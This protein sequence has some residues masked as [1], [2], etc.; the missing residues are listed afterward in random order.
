MSTAK[1]LSLQKCEAVDM[2]L[3]SAIPLRPRASGVHGGIIAIDASDTTLEFGDMTR[4]RSLEP[5]IECLCLLLFEHGH[6]FLTQE[7]GA[8]EVRTGLRE[9]LNLV[10][11]LGG[12]FLWWHTHQKG[13]CS[14]G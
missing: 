14:R 3:R 5:G 10:L 6:T 4:F 12:Q 2:S 9:V 13:R 11:V 1:H 8:V 7:I